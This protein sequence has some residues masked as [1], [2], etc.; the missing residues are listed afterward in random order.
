MIKGMDVSMIMELESYG[1]SYYLNGKKE[2]LFCLLKTCGVNMVRLRIW[3]DPYDE[4]GNPYGGGMNDLKTTIEIARRVVE[5]GMEIML[6]FHYSDFWADPAKQV[7]PK[8]W[9]ALSG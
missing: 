5:N 6:D 8:A 3:P 7:K 9:K 1:A 4:E 2:D